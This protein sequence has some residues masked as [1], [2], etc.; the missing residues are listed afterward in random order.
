LKEEMSSLDIAAITVEFER[1]LRGLRIV[2]VYQINPKTLLLKLR[3]VEGSSAQLLIEAGKRVHLTSYVFEKPPKPPDFCMALRKYLNNGVVEKAQQYEFERI[4][5]TTVKNRGEAYRL[6]VEL[7]GEGNIIL[8]DAENRI[9]HALAYR[10]MRDRNILKGDVFVYP[11][12]RGENPRNVTRENFDE[13]RSLGQIDVARGLTRFLS[14]GGFYTEE[15]LLRAGIDKKIHCAS[16]SDSDLDAFFNSLQE[17]VSEITAG[18]V[19]P[20]IFIDESG[21]WI[22]V[23]PLLLNKYAH[24]KTIRVRTFNEALDEYYSKVSIGKKAS[25]VEEDVGREVARLERILHE[26]EENLR[27]LKAKAE[28]CQKLGNVV[29]NHLNDLEVLSQRIMDEKRSGKRWAE[30][31]ETLQR[32]KNELRFPAVYFQAVKPETVSLQVSAEGQ[33]FDLDLKKSVQKN[34]AEYYTRAKKARMKIEGLNNA[35]KETREKIERA[36]LRMVEKIEKASKPQPKEKRRDWYEKFHWFCSS[37]GFLVIGGRDALTNEVLIKKYM[38]P[39]DV[40]FH[41]DIAGAPF[42]IVKTKEG[43]LTEQTIK[44]AASFAAS[45][46]RAWKASFRAMDVY[47]VKPEQLSKSPPS[48]QYLPA[49]SFMIYGTKNFVKNVPLE[50]SIGVKKEK[51]LLR[52]VGGPAEAIAKQTSLYVRLIPGN[53]P[54]G[55][56]AKKIKSRLAQLASVDERK[57]IFNI[58]L[59]EIQ[60]FIPSG[61]GALA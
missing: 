12:S 32:E 18:N 41:A 35:I 11:P 28:V 10:R 8:V 60:R 22:D 6:I 14:I 33:T 54:S 4:V 24:L 53:E 40:V 61:Q 43:A 3:R 34:A 45:Y 56:L 51:E 37:D 5:E 27:D 36:R 7:F 13:I 58:S 29:Y 2:N 9:L 16:L 39:Q 59:E 44:E 15:I 21:N 30:I 25:E 1:L 52:I 31:I 20:C 47:W 55:K 38:E 50:V 42:V 57:E 17:L 26:Q 23:A 48:G 49:G 46:S 19:K